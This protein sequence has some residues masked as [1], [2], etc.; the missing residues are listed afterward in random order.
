MEE[1]KDTLHNKRN[2]ELIKEEDKDDD[3]GKEWSVI[4]IVCWTRSLS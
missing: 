3:W 1:D 2:K 4:R